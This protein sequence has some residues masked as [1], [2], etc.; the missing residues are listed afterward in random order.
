MLDQDYLFRKHIRLIGA[1]IIVFLAAVALYF[2]FGSKSGL[3]SLNISADKKILDASNI[4][5]GDKSYLDFKQSGQLPENKAI[6]TLM[7]QGKPEI[8]RGKKILSDAQKTIITERSFTHGGDAF[9]VTDK[10]N[11]SGLLTEG[12]GEGQLKAVFDE[13]ANEYSFMAEMKRFPPSPSGYYY[14]GWVV[15]S[16]PFRY[17]SIGRA[18]SKDDVSLIFYQSSSNVLDHQFFV[19][20]LEADDNNAAPSVHVLEGY[21]VPVKP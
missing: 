20:T 2:I 18:E 10:Q 8:D 17:I 3:P 1:I 15:R 5:S 16:N 11:V 9:D 19:L 12:K 6:K 4:V 21:I 13:K 14:E 7:E